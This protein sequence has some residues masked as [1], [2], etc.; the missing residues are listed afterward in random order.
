[1]PAHRLVLIRHAKSDYPPG[2]A[3]HER[4]LNDRG[5]RDAPEVGRWLAANVTPSGTTVVIVS[6]AL[7]TQQTWAAASPCL[8]DAWDSVRIETDDRIYEASPWALREVVRD[9]P[10]VETIVLVGHS[11]GLPQLVAEL[12]RP[13]PLRAQ[14]LAK[15][16]TSCVAVLSTSEAWDDSLQAVGSFDVSSF[17]IL[18]G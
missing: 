16:P 12:G 8:S 6:S 5:R 4:P 18:R 3:D 1:M 17:A 14:A 9:H 11:P 13:S 15:F 2:V 7:R 10:E